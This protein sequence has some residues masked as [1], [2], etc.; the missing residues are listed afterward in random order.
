MFVRKGSSKNC[1]ALQPRSFFKLVFHMENKSR[2][3]IANLVTQ[4]KEEDEEKVSVCPNST[5]DDSNN[6]NNPETSI[7]DGLQYQWFVQVIS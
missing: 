7:P 4:S 5:S 2:I 3:S 6:N 1:S